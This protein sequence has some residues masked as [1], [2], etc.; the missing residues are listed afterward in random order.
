RPFV[1]GLV[2]DAGADPPDGAAERSV[3][4]ERLVGV[5]R[6]LNV[7]NVE[8]DVDLLELPRPRVE[9]LHLAETARLRRQRCRRMAGA[10][11]RLVL[12]YPKTRGHPDATLA[13]HGGVV[14]DGR[15]VPIELIS[16]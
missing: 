4:V 5:L 14:R 8:A 13:V 12:R 1:A 6:E 10:E 9:V 3:A 11:G 15:V 16:P 7:V 2:E